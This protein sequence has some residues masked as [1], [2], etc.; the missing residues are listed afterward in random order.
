MGTMITEVVGT[1]ENIRAG[2]KFLQTKGVHV[3][4]IGYVKQPHE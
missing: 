1:A 3:E 2:M 4:V